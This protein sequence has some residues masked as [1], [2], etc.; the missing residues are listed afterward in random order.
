[1]KKNK[2][3]ENAVIIWNVLNNNNGVMTFNQLKLTTQL[4][5]KDLFF[6]LGWLYKEDKIYFERNEANFKIY[7]TDN[8]GLNIL[9]K[10]I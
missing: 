5:E 1:M 8:I 7:L 10:L 2:I 6:A 4:G 9:S 3:G